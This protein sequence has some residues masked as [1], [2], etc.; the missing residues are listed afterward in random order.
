MEPCL[1]AM[2]ST[3]GRDGGMELD[4]VPKEVADR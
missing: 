4:Q 3:Y 2:N 1:S